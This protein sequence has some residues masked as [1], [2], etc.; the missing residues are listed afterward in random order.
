MNGTRLG[1]YP[2]L[3]K[4]L[5]KR[6]PKDTPSFPIDLA[7]GM[8]AG[9]AGAA[10]G[11][12]FQLIKTRMM[13]YSKVKTTLLGQQ[14]KYNSLLHGIRTVV[15]EE[16]LAGLQRAVKACMLKVAVASSVQLS[17]YDLCKR[18]LAKSQAW[19]EGASP[20]ATHIV[21]ALA[22]SF[23]VVSVINPIEVVNTRL[24]NQTGNVYKSAVD[25]FCKTLAK[26]GI[27]GLYKG[28]PAHFMRVAPHTV[29]TFVFVEA[30][31]SQYIELKGRQQEQRGS[32][33]Q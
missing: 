9:V 24:Y 14:H 10:L 16:G 8:M 33:S 20:T 27:Q 17:T 15:K 28:Y 23:C 18:Q 7:S 29:L 30:L 25:C 5:K 31:R 2:F 32:L 19:K 26:E 13:A 1:I 3:K 12:P 4:S 11:S 6:L 21:S 22:A